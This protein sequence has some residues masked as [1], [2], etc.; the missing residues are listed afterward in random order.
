MAGDDAIAISFVVV[1]VSIAAGV[2]CLFYGYKCE[3]AELR[4]EHKTDHCKNIHND[5]SALALIVFGWIFLVPAI[6]AVFMCVV[7]SVFSA[8]CS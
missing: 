8:I 6:I 3:N 4:A 7:V 2:P 5:D 1:I